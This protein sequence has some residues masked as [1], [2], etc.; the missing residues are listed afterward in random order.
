[1]DN[2]CD[3]GALCFAD[4]DGDG[5]GSTS[6]IAS[7]DADCDDE[8]EAPTT[9]DCD[10]AAADVN[11][12]AADTTCNGVDD[13]CDGTIDWTIDALYF[14]GTGGS[15]VDIP[16]TSAA[17]LALT[18]PFVIEAWLRWDGTAGGMIFN[19]WVF[20]YE[21][22]QIGLYDTGELY[23]TTFVKSGTYI[24]AKS[25]TTH[26]APDTWTHLAYT[27]NTGGIVRMFLNGALAQLRVSAADVYTA[28]FTPSSALTATSDTLALW[29]LDEGT[30]TTANDSAGSL[31]GTIT[32]ATWMPVSCI[33]D[34]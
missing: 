17:D 5:W 30:G 32:G 3:G 9:G 34:L 11:P 6:E 28:E 29:K 18:T 20:S 21:D 16:V 26:L 22:K 19:K 1:M 13:D 8:G 27:W 15:Y 23:G 7:D 14:D 31:T 2:D 10:D 12:D 4:A 24:T 25:G 33:P